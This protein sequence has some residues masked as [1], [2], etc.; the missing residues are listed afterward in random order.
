VGVIF[1]DITGCEPGESPAERRQ[2]EAREAAE[3]GELVI[4]RGVQ[5]WSR[6]LP[7]GVRF[8]DTVPAD[9]WFRRNA[10]TGDEHRRR[11]LAAQRL[12]M[13]DAQIARLAAQRDRVCAV[14]DGN[15]GS[16]DA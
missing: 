16:W 1:V 15:G 10:N 9:E 2:R 5:Y 8:E 4:Y 13:L 12:A 14:L 7:K 6:R 3:R 11:T